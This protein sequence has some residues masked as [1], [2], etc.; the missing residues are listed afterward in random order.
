M[1]WEL[2]VIIRNSVGNGPPSQGP[3]FQP[4]NLHLNP[5]LS[6]FRNSDIRLGMAD[7]GEG[8]RSVILL[9]LKAILY[10]RI[11]ANESAL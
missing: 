2:F 9:C 3:P 10:L 8:G 7:P 5:D 1:A 6:S 4:A 11:A